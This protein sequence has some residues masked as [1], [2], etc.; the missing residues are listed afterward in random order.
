[1]SARVWDVS[2]PSKSGQFKSGQDK[3]GQVKIGQVRIG[4]VSRNQV[5]IGQVRT[6][7]MRTDHGWKYLRTNIFW[8]Q[9]YLR[10]K[11][12]FSNSI[13]FSDLKFFWLN[14]F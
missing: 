9:D 12:F 6:G 5:R 10:R 13:I 8:T 2:G 7:P 14:V 11:T 3:S 1:M 4:Q